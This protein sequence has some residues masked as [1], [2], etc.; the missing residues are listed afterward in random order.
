MYT[1]YLKKWIPSKNMQDIHVG[2]R[3]EFCMMLTVKLP[4]FGHIILCSSGRRNP[5][6]GKAIGDGW[7][8]FNFLLFFCLWLISTYCNSIMNPIYIQIKCDYNSQLSPYS[9]CRECSLAFLISSHI[10]IYFHF[11]RSSASK[12]LT[13]LKVLC[14]RL[15][16]RILYSDRSIDWR[17]VEC[18]WTYVLFS[19]LQETLRHWL[20]VVR[21]EAT[22]R[23][24]AHGAH[25]A[26]L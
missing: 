23:L 19:D 25:A 4:C 18:C 6:D 22:N 1:F 14:V 20:L 3:F 13:L 5:N 10:Y 12:I 21:L 15:W 7:L 11:Q 24:V 8:F 2:E 16:N 9:V 17:A 26:N